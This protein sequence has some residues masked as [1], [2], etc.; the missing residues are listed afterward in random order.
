MDGVWLAINIYVSDP[1]LV[2]HGAGTEA[3]AWISGRP[4][5]CDALHSALDSSRWIGYFEL[6]PHD[7]FLPT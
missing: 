6:S 3:R 4:G 7:R 2:N 5:K 1:A